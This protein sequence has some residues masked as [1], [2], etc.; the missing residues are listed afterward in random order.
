L[1]I[2]GL[3]GGG[4][5]KVAPGTPNKG[6]LVDS[7]N[8]KS[9]GKRSGSGDV[10]IGNFEEGES[11]LKSFAGNKTRTEVLNEEIVTMFENWSSDILRD[12]STWDTLM[13]SARES[14][15]EKLRDTIARDSAQKNLAPIAGG[16]LS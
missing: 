4:P 7:F 1:Q 6:M 13:K 8:K 3:E 5:A 12:T 9:T 14:S 2:E 11:P 16:I 15:L 10:G